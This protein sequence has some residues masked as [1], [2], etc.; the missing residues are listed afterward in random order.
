[1]LFLFPLGQ[2]GG[3]R[4]VGGQ[5]HARGQQAHAQ[6]PG[7]HHLALAQE[8]RFQQAVGQV[9]GRLHPG[10]YGWRLSR[11]TPERGLDDSWCQARGQ[12][13]LGGRCREQGCGQ[14]GPKGQAAGGQ[15]A[16]Q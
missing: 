12:G 10:R 5:A 14:R 3:H 6:E 4:P 7:R 13:G 8:H 2:R 9:E 16:V 15:A 1:L 11:R